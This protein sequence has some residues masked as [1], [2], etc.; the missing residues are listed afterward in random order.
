MAPAHGVLFEEARRALHRRLSAL[1]TDRSSFGLIHADLHSRNVM[2]DGDRLVII[3]FDD[4]GFG[5]YVHELAVALHPSWHEPWF[6]DARDAL[7][8]GY[9]TVHPLTDDE[10]SLLPAFLTIR[11]MMIVAWLDAR[12]ELGFHDWLP[13]IIEQAAD[14][15]ERYLAG[16][17]DASMHMRR[18]P[19]P[20]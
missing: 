12:P 16:P 10:L 18:A 1:A 5:W 7:V 11:S 17:G 9:R 15:A 19:A 20:G 8:A 13:D 4:S 6:I 2:V 3:D 14:D